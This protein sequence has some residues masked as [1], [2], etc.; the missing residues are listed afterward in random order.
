VANETVGR[1]SRIV[2]WILF[3]FGVGCMGFGAWVWLATGGQ[4]VGGIFGFVFFIGGLL[5]AVPSFTFATTGRIEGL[6]P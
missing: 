3:A 6:L 1:A 4:D 5:V 2:G